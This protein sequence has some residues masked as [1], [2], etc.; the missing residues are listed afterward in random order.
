M[1]DE[2]EPVLWDATCRTPG[3]DNENITL[4]VPAD[5]ELPLVFCGPCGAQIT[6]LLTT[7][8]AA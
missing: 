1:D 6:D 7:E 3:C 4:R 2:L 8:G 5:P